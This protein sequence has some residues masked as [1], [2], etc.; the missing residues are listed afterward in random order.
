MRVCACIA[1][2]CLVGAALAWPVFWYSLE[3]LD[4]RTEVCW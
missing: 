1:A 4:G 2:G 3:L